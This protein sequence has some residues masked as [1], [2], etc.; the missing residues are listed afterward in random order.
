[1]GALRKPQLE[2]ADRGVRGRFEFAVGDAF[3]DLGVAR[4]VDHDTVA[5]QH[6]FEV[7]ERRAAVAFPNI[8]IV[9][10]GDGVV[11][12]LTGDTQ[13][14][15]GITYSKFESA[16][17][18]PISS[19][20]LRL[21]QGPHSVLGSFIPAGGYSFCGLT[22]TVTSTK[23]LKRHGRTVTVKTHKTVAATLEMPTTMTAQNGAVFTQDTKI[24]VTGCPTAKASKA[25]AAKHTAN[26]ARRASRTPRRR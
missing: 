26:K 10:Q 5:L 22:K 11:I 12:D 19:F 8:E 13:I 14:T 20:E 9:L 7:G 2:A 21:P 6:D 17:D 24:A 25:K 3:R 1:V 16:P 18:A 15:K 23:K 4:Q